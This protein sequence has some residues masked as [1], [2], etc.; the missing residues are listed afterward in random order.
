MSVQKRDDLSFDVFRSQKPRSYQ[1][2]PLF[3]AIDICRNG[4]RGYIILQVLLQVLWKI[5][6][7]L[8]S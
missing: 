1:A 3:G 6:S 8:L 4:Q 7:R 5:K 2:R